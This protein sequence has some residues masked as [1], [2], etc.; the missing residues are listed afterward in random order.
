MGKI[1][2]IGGGEIGRS[3]YPIETEK[4]DKEIIRLTGKKRPKLLFVPTASSDSESYADVAK[5]YFGKRL[6]CRVDVLYLLN[7]KLSKKEIEEKILKSDI[8]YV[9]GGNTL[10]MMNAWRRLGVDKI[11]KKAFKKNIVLSGLSAGSLCWFNGGSSDSRKFKN[12]KEPFIKVTGLGFINAFHC[13]HYDTEKGRKKSLK[14]LMKKTPG[15]AI[16]L[17]NC[18]AIE[19]VNDKYRILTTKKQTNAYRTYWLKGKYFEEIIKPKKEFS[20][21]SELLGKQKLT[22]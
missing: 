14:D 7:K 2:A 11:L 6:G 12:D 19:I 20:L 15:T 18:S 5:K 8:V 16:A 10:K 4:I 21:L 1:I 17:D 13:P 9:G 3:G 22:R